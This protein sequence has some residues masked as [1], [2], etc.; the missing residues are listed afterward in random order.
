MCEKNRYN[1]QRGNCNVSV[2]R[3]NNNNAPWLTR[4]STAWQRKFAKLVALHK[5][6]KYSALQRTDFFQPSA[7]EYLGP[8][9][10]VAYSFLAD[11]ARKISDISGNDR[12]S[13]YLFQQISVL[14]QCYNTILLHESFTEENHPDQWPLGC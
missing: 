9:N 10:I 8:T 14:L 1:G 3:Y 6:E 7:V 11:L 2:G 13:S 5:V 4:T 12:E